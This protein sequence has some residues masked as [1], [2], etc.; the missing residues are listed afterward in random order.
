M[1][2]HTDK[3]LKT[4]AQMLDFTVEENYGFFFLGF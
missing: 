2:T 1:S 3:N 4:L